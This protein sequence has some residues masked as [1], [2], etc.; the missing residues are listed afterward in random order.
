MAAADKFYYA[1]GRRK[2]S[3]ARVFLK[4]GKGTITI[5]GKK[6][7]DYL[8]RMQSRMV[9][10]QPLDLLNQIGKFDAKITVA[11]GGESGQAG[12]IRLGITR[13]LIAFNPEFKGILKKAG[14][15]TRDPRMVERKKYGKAGARRRFQYSKR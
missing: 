12:A 5:N 11:G 10:V 6:S 13:A 1:T 4:P 15:V 7:E 8:T 14:F 3:A 9:I 2:T